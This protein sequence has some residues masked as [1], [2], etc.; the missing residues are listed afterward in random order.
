MCI[1][2]VGGG[3]GVGVLLAVRGVEV[4]PGLRVDLAKINETLTYLRRIGMESKDIEVLLG[5][6]RKEKK[7]GNWRGSENHWS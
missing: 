3:G 5:R 6:P 4:N 7:K 2:G 1:F